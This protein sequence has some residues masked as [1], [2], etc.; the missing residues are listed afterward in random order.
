MFQKADF[1]QTVEAVARD[2]R[3]AKLLEII[4]RDRSNLVTPDLVGMVE[5]AAGIAS[6][7]GYILSN[8]S[9]IINNLT[10]LKD[11]VPD[12]ENAQYLLS[13]EPI[14]N[15]LRGGSLDQARVAASGIRLRLAIV[16]LEA[17][18]LRYIAENGAV[19]QRDA[20]TP[21]NEP[22]CNAQ[23]EALQQARRA[24]ETAYHNAV[25]QNREAGFRYQ[26]AIRLA[27]QE[28]EGQGLYENV[29]ELEKQLAICR[30]G[31]GA[32]LR[33]SLVDGVLASAGIPVV[34]PTVVLGSQHYGDGGVREV[35]PIDACVRLNADHI[36]AVSASPLGLKQLPW[37]YPQKWPLASVADR[38]SS[39]L[40]D[41][42]VSTDLPLN[43][44]VLLVSPRFEVHGMT[45]VDPG[46]IRIA[47]HYGYMCAGD[48]AA[49]WGIENHRDPIT[50]QAENRPRPL[51]RQ[52]EQAL[53]RIQEAEH[54]A[55]VIIRI[56]M[57]IWAIENTFFPPRNAATLSTIR[58]LKGLVLH[59]V[60]A[61]QALGAIM[62]DASELDTWTSAWEL[63]DYPVMDH[64]W[65]AQVGLQAATPGPIR[66]VRE[67]RSGALFEFDRAFKHLYTGPVD[68]SIPTVDDGIVDWFRIGNAP[69]L[70]GPVIF[71]PPAGP[72]RPGRPSPV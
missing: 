7:S 40:M 29:A 30:S 67:R 38:A 2:P 37:T 66:R 71:G 32:P 9:K 53:A 22:Q 52:R 65:A 57:A 8:A 44:G 3:W 64:P 10:D 21:Y 43:A 58:A 14:A 56:R 11:I 12:V 5:E 70:Q 59:L 20:T 18:D 31:P 17:G 24:L 41:E 55:D 33:V 45:E 34:F 48:A 62:P 36:V 49:K 63:H 72:R 26:D 47:M 16:S 1:V 13:L 4:N 35:F 28:L 46:L 42:I 39:I 6:D 50:G 15:R 69:V 60:E 19:L 61:R 54:T 68:A 27:R 25:Q 23:L 51:P